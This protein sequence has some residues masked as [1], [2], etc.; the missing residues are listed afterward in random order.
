MKNSVPLLLSAVLVAAAISP[1]RHPAL[2]AGEKSELLTPAPADEP[3]TGRRGTTRP[4]PEHRRAVIR[5]W[6]V[7]VSQ[8][9]FDR[10]KGQ[11]DKMLEMLDAHLAGVVKAVPPAAVE[12]LR[13][14]PIWVS[15]PYRGVPPRAEYHPDARW[16]RAN[17]RDPAMAKGV[18]IT[19]VADF[20]RETLR[21]PVFVLHELAHAYHDRVLGF[22]QPD[23]IACYKRA[24]KSGTYESVDRFLGPGRPVKKVRAYAMTNEREYFA[25]CSEAFFGRND[26]YPFTRDELEKH[27]PE[28]FKVLERLWNRPAPDGEPGREAGAGPTTK[29]R[30]KSGGET[31]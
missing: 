21:M 26:F 23:V 6:T 19:D 2:A 9:L 11:T 15:S 31:E 30:P 20:E 16:L 10:Q 14:V 22:D 28:M 3:E 7:H 4:S 29:P 8:E 12:E 5:G 25:E 1:A 27:D 17:G 13:K 18:E 24:K